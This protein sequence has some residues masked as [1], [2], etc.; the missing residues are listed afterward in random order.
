[1]KN[2]QIKILTKGIL[3][4]GAGKSWMILLVSLLTLLIFTAV[5]VTVSS[6]IENSVINIGVS[7]FCVFV[8]WLFRCAFRSGSSAW[9]SFYKNKN[10]RGKMIYWFNPK[11]V[12]HSFSLYASLFFRKLFWTSLLL[13]PGILTIFS[14]CYL[15]YDTGLEFN[16]FICGAAGGGLITLAGLLFR[17]LIVQRYFL[18]QSLFVSSPGMKASQAIRLS[19]EIMNGQLKKTALFK[20]SFMPWFLLCAG[21]LPVFYVWPYYRQ[22]CAVFSREIQKRKLLT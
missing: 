3:S 22:S 8:Y 6:F 7:F 5:P 10:Q 19:C 14:F 13:L 20:L 21:I 16:L 15:A 1:M 12:I 9:F 4:S 2:S 11:R 17:F 18:A